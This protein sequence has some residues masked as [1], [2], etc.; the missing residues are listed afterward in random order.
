[1]ILLF[2]VAVM[3]NWFFD[4]IFQAPGISLTRLL[5]ALGRGQS[6]CFVTGSDQFSFGLLYIVIVDSY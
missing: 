4:L 5:C 3:K 2:P 6:L 1:M